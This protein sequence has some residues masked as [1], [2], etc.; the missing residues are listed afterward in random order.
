[1]GDFMHG[2]TSA[3]AEN[4]FVILEARDLVKRY[5]SQTQPALNGFSLTVHQ[6]NIFGL[7][8]PNGAGKTTAIGIMCSLLAPDSGEIYCFGSK[9]VDKDQGFRR[10]MGIVPQEIALYDSL[11][12][13]ENVAFCGRLYGLHGKALE[14]AVEW[15]LDITNLPDYAHQRLA[16][17]SGGLKRRVNLAAGLVHRPRLLFLDEPT[18]GIDAQSRRM[19]LERLAVLHHYDMTLIYTTHYMEEAQSLCTHLA[20]MDQGRILESGQSEKLLESHPECSDL[21]ALFFKLTGKH[22]RT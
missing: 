1:M 15:S 5:K 4:E 9:R 2:L 16:I 18:V 8:G 13:R 17:L 10:A 3:S 7:L 6:H 20:I 22:L 11:S 12:V 19:I 14:K 21:Y